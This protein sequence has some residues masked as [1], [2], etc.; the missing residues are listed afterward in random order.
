MFSMTPIKATY[1]EKNNYFLIQN[2][3]GFSLNQFLRFVKEKEIIIQSG[4]KRNNL[5]V[6]RL[7]KFQST[8]I[9][10]MM[11]LRAF[12]ISTPKFIS[13]KHIQH[14]QMKREFQKLHKRYIYQQHK[15]KNKINKSTLIGQF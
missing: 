12:F 3:A 6:N 4:T 10:H 11:K 14:K 9:K 2:L 1:V 5:G 7:D 15:M 13:N 8:K